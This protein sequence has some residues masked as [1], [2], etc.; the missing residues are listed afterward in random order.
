[1]IQRSYFSMQVLQVNIVSDTEFDAG[2]DAGS[3]ADSGSDAG[4]GEAAA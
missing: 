3:D 1:M 4:Q 2:S